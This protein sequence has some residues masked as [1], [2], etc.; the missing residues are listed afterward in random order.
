ME[1][2]FCMRTDKYYIQFKVVLSPMIQLMGMASNITKMKGNGR[3]SWPSVL[4]YDMI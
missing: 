1:L 4:R 2:L 3:K